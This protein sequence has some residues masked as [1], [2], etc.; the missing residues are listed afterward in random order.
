[1]R[2]LFLSDIFPFKPEP[3]FQ[4]NQIPKGANNPNPYPI[5]K[6]TILIWHPS[7]NLQRA[8]D[9]HKKGWLTFEQFLMMRGW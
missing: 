8:V 4:P 9:P 7:T 1:M 5:K 2:S 6:S 3:K